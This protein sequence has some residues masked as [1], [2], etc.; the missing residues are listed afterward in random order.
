MATAMADKA[1]LTGL[2]DRL[3]RS[4]FRRRFRLLEPERDYL[5]RKG[6]D[7]VLEHAAEFIEQRLAPAEP[8]ND[9]KQTPFRH[10][11]VFIAQ[12]AT[13]TCCRGCLEQ[14][15]SIQKGRPLTQKEKEYILLVL[16]TWLGNQASPDDAPTP[17]QAELDF[18]DL[19]SH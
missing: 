13:A 15:H 5:R 4:A 19:D 17:V 7:K 6:L 9:G 14:W 8:A 1:D 11:P 16:K 18:G 3:S 2:F 10:H 12:H